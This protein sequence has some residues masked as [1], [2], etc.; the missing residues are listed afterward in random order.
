MGINNIPVS[1][2]IVLT[3]AAILV[4]CAPQAMLSSDGSTAGNTPPASGAVPAGS[5]DD[6]ASTLPPGEE[7][8]LVTSDRVRISG[9]IYPSNSSEGVVLLPM[10]RHDRTSYA[11][12]ILSLT[13]K[14]AV[15]AID[16]RGHGK[17]SGDLKQFGPADFA[18]ME[19]DVEAARRALGKDNVAIIGASIGAN[20]G[21]MYAARDP[22]VK[23]VIML[24]PGLDYRGVAIKK[25]MA[26]FNR[27]AHL[28]ASRGDEYSYKSVQELAKANN[29]SS[30]Q[31]YP[32]Q[33]HG[34]DLFTSGTGIEEIIL[35]ILSIDFGK[36]LPAEDPSTGG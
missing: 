10:L 23:S 3:F 27:P 36:A 12:I 32:G 14:Y 33:L 17:S 20:A 9:T 13:K 21:L 7:V 1:L 30:V 15:I 34:T 8:T 24:S 11:P 25:T 22:S 28:F 5:P 26:S 4:G 16:M 31:T 19:K 6:R 35:N 29:H 18:G 2:F